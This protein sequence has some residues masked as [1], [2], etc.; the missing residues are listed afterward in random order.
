MIR[1]TLTTE[2][3]KRKPREGKG[4]AGQA[5]APSV[6]PTKNAPLILRWIK[7]ANSLFL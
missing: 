1:L 4:G 7:A 6:P 3:P 2:H 5:C